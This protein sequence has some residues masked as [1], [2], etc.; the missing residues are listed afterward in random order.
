[1]QDTRDASAAMRDIL[2]RTVPSLNSAM[3]QLSASVGSFSAALDAQKG[4]LA[5][6]DQLLAGLDSQ[7][8]AT[9]SALQSFDN[10]LAGIEQ[11][12]QTSR[13]DVV[14]LNAHPSGV[15][16]GTLTDLEP[17]QIAQFISSPVEVDEHLVFPVDTYGS[18]MA[19][20]FTNCRCGSAPSCSW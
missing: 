11:G 8:V 19:A 2:T 6:A 5:Q 20:L 12:L 18:A 4:V 7:L 15:L 9:S 17:E 13:T 16:L 10:D 14:A 1:M 3:S